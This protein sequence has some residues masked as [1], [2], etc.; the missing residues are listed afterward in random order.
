MNLIECT[1]TENGVLAK[2]RS[3]RRGARALHRLKVVRQQQGIS[4]HVVARYLGIGIREVRRQETETSDLPLSVLY[5]WQEVLEVPVASLLID[6]DDSLVS[7]ILERTQLLRLMKTVMAIRARAKQQS[8]RR[9]AQTM[10]DQLVQM[11]P[12]L[13][14]VTPWPMLGVL[15]EQSDIG[16][17]AQRCLGLAED[18]FVDAGEWSTL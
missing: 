6:T 18:V 11:M 9:M 3:Q 4:E 16:M 8:V 7:P 12:E 2:A 17:A 14:D 10:Y 13:T 5:D 1:V 15:R